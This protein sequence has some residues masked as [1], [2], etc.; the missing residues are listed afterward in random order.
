MSTPPNY[1]L[2]QSAHEQERL[3]FQ[4]R[5]LRLYTEKFLR[6]A[7]VGPGMHVLDLGSGMGDV[8]LLA[9][10][11]VGPGGRVMGLD[12]DGNALDRARERT[13]QNGCASWVSFQAV[14]LADFFTTER[15]DAIIGRYVLLY[16]TDPAATIRHF[17]SFLKDGGIV[18]FHEADFDNYIRSPSF[19]PCELYDQVYAV[20]AEV[21]RRGGAPPDFGRRLGKTFLDA[22]LSF[23]TIAAEAVIGGGRRSFLIPWVAAT[24]VSLA[25]RMADLK[26]TLPAGIVLD[27]AL[28]TKLED[29][30]VK[31]GCQ[32]LGPMQYG[33]WT[34]KM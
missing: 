34:R 3:M 6:T 13:K 23:S 29:A 28:A 4:A 27:H 7:G 15:F 14:N 10:D 8:A 22:G 5:V 16:Q 31:L 12:C 17:A 11:I 21:F 1:V 9:G 19:P 26:V 2:G 33:A 32:V 30:V 18:L 20:I 25:P 24:I